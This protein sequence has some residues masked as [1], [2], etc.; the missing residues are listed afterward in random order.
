MAY[1]CAKNV[2]KKNKMLIELEKVGID[3]KK[4][5][6]EIAVK[7]PVSSFENESIFDV[8]RKIVTKGFRRIPI[9]DKKMNLVGIVTY[10]DLLDAFL[11]NE[12]LNQ[13]ISFI[14]VREVISCDI[15]DDLEFVLQKMKLS[16]RGGLPVLDKKKLF[17]IVTERDFINNFVFLDFGI[18][19]KKVMTPNPLHFSKSLSIYDTVKTLVS[20]KYRRF[21]VVENKKVIGIIT[22]MDIFR[23]ILENNF[24]FETLD[25]DMKIIM[26]KDVFKVN[27]ED[28]L[29]VAVNLMKE[30]NVGGVV[31]VNKENDL[32]GIVTERDIIN[33]VV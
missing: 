25:E 19:V 27:G 32:I 28:D 15:N 9:V 7:N 1:G 2:W 24:R 29:S 33:Q 11:R 4:K 10:T 12:D 31:V 16:R 13:K 14:M 18:K 21:P 3:R 26:R 22:G 17:G 30:K 8:W 23:Y 5:I 20:T 6:T